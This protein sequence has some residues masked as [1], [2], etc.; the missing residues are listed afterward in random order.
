MSWADFKLNGDGMVP[1]VT[2]DYKTGEVLC[3]MSNP[4]F[5]PLDPP[6]IEDG[7]ERWE[8]V[9]L[10]RFLSTAVTSG[11]V[12]KTVTMAAARGSEARNLAIL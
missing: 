4:S 8:G 3:M 5:D 12:F 11:S 7:D 10:N 1:V 9:Y 2:Q 6:A